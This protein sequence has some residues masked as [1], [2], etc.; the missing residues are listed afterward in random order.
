MVST[1]I[2]EQSL[3]KWQSRQANVESPCMKSFPS[4]CYIFVAEDSFPS[5][6][7]ERRRLLRHFRIPTFVLTDVCFKSNGYFGHESAYDKAGKMNGYITWFRYIIKIVDPSVK[8]GSN[9][10][11]HEMSFFTQWCLGY[12]MCIIMGAPDGLRKGLEDFLLENPDSLNFTD[13]FA[14]H[15]PLM[16]R[17]IKMYDISVW[18]VRDL[19][20]I[21]EKSRACNPAIEPD[22]SKMHEDARHAIHCSETLEVAAEVLAQ[23][24]REHA[25][26][27]KKRAADAALPELA[28]EKSQSY[29]G[30]QLQMLKNL[31]LRSQ[32]NHERLNNEITLAYNMIMQRDSKVMMAIGQAAK[33]DSKVMVAIGQ[34]A[35]DDSSAMR[36]IAVVTMAFLP[37]TFTAAVFSMSFFNF[38]PGGGSHPGNWSISGKF[39]I[40]WAFALPLTGVTIATWFRWQAWINRL[41]RIQQKVHRL[42]PYSS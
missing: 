37:A 23:I 27:H 1:Q 33:D 26:F 35:K 4:P 17:V 18:S 31:K 42:S 19:V 14:M 6:E 12:C 7:H 10:T 39:W 5:E 2:L 28:V 20:R 38:T 32:A 22:F 41:P 40:Y 29:I 21:V 25:A 34:A 11:W 8:S 15:V 36:A 24:K 30:F 16:D 9:Y 3:G 13:P